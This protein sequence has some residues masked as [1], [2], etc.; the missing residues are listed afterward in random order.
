MI[1]RL[2]RN[3]SLL[4]FSLLFGSGESRAFFQYEFTNNTSRVVADANSTVYYVV[5]S[6]TE[7]PAVTPQDMKLGSGVPVWNFSVP[8]LQLRGFYQVRRIS[9]FAPEDA[10]G[11]YIDDVYE[12]NHPALN[13]LNSADA[14]LDPDHNGRTYLQEYLDDVFGTAGSTL[15]FYSRE[16]STF[17]FGADLFSQ[18]A[19][20]KELSLWNFGQDPFSV[21]AISLELSVYNGD[22]VPTS[23]ILQ[24]YSSET[25]LWNNG[26]ELFSLEAF[27]HEVSVYNGDV[28]P[29][30]D[31]LEVYSRETTVWNHGAELFS[32]EAISREMTVFNDIP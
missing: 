8:P 28:V 5:S 14:A 29:T 24:V 26:V 30:S 18:E 31:I 16:V 11:D 12:I 25:T 13:P 4:L 17:N 20:S 2:G 27:S 9:V 21:E 7:I 6:G 19:I 32:L 15:Q 23:D 22:V 3:I 10:D 1:S